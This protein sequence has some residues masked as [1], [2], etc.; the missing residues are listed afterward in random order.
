MEHENRPDEH[1]PN[2][3]RF[4]LGDIQFGRLW[5][6]YRGS[7]YMSI[8]IARESTNGPNDG[9]P[10]VVYQTQAGAVTDTKAGRAP[11]TE[12]RTREAGEF[13][14]GRFRPMA[15]EITDGR[16]RLV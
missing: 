3:E 2:G 6:H 16:L 12:L 5:R 10:T 13:L 4:E 15:G 8:G 9:R 7:I 14:D 11:Q 1:Q